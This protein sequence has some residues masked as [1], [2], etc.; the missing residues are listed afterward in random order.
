VHRPDDRWRLAL[1][2][3][4][5]MHDDDVG[6]ARVVGQRAKNCCSASTPSADAP[7]PHTEI[8]GL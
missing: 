7:I 2:I 1:A 8:K 4:R 3:R 6:E 5:E